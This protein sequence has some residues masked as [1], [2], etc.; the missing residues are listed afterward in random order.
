MYVRNVA[1]YNFAFKYRDIVIYIPYDGKLYSIPDDSGSYRE[2]RVI[3]AMH[4]RTQNVTYINKDGNT[5][6]EKLSGHK[7]R[8]RPT[9]KPVDPDQPLKGV[10]TNR[11]KKQAEKKE[12]AVDNSIINVDLDD[13]T[14]K[15]ETKKRGRPA[16]KTTT[17]KT[18]AKKPTGKKRGRPAKK[19][20]TTDK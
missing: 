16:K 8:G 17:K 13:T 4:V 15:K 2:L 10:T 1:G 14:E 9:K 3:P 18:T 11:I 6:S 20:K 5:A 12:P 19:T 7:R